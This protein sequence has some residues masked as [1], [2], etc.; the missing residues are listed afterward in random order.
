MS[1]FDFDLFVIGAGFR[2]VQGQPHGCRLWRKGRGGR[3]SLSGRHTASIVGC[4][5]K[6]AVCLFGAL[7]EDLEDAKGYGWNIPT[8]L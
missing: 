1:E 5:P 2:R 3:G 8:H 7:F 4:V 6:K